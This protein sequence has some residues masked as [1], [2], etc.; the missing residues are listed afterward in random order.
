MPGKRAP[1]NPRDPDN[2]ASR[3]GDLESGFQGVAKKRRFP[4]FKD[5]VDLAIA[6]RTTGALKKQ[7]KAGVDIDEFERYRK[8]DDEVSP[9]NTA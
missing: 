7:L 2:D 8:T 9:F 3:D 4:K 6:D 1:Q 5:A